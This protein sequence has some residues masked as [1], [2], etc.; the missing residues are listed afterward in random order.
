MSGELHGQVA[1]EP[2][3][4]LNDDRLC[5]VRCQ[6]A[7][8]LAKTRA[9][10]DGIGTTHCSIVV[11]VHDGV[12]GMFER[13]KGGA[14]NAL[15]LEALRRG[16]HFKVSRSKARRTS[17]NFL[18]GRGAKGNVLVTVYERERRSVVTA[19]QIER[20]ERVVVGAIDINHLAW[21]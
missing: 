8:H 15:T 3:G 20:L 14:S 13:L 4:R 6:P 19:L 12:L 10:I 11:F 17:L 21:I 9:L 2:I 1:G 7:Q 18:R 5:P 16:K